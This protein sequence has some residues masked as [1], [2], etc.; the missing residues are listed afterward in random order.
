ML[1]VIMHETTGAVNVALM[2]ESGAVPNT[3]RPMSALELDKVA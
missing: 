3:P 2:L 1:R